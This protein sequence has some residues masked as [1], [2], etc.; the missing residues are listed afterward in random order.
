MFGEV[1]GRVMVNPFTSLNV[2][3]ILRVGIAGLCFLLSLLSF[4]LVQREQQQEGDPRKGILQAIYTFMI[5]NLVTAALVAASGYLGARLPN[6]SVADELGATTYLTDT[7]SYFVDLT[8]WTEQAL[9]PVEITRSDSIRK[10]SDTH[11]NYEVPY[12]TTGT[13][14]DAKFL[15]HTTEPD[16][17]GPSEQHGAEGKHYLYKIAI[18]GQPLGYTEYV[19]TMF[20]FPNGFKDPNSEWWQASVAYPS[21]TVSVVIRFPASKPCKKIRVFKIPGIGDQKPIKE[22]EP[23]LSNEK[24]I[25]TW[26]GL[27]FEGKSRIEFDWDW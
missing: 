16:F 3:E 2:P 12:Y 11:D 25:A 23:V 21:R 27:N 18:G 17:D 9:G 1:L 26:V 24:M 4:W 13:G 15:T 19:S 6:K 5:V 20:T 10:V 14:I 7:L 8:K 22:N